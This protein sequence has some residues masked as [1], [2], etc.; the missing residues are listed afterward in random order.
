MRGHVTYPLNP[1]NF[2]RHLKKIGEICLPMILAVRINILAQ[3]GDFPKPISGRLTDFFQDVCRIATAL[4][5]SYIG[6]DTVSTEIIAA[7][8]NGN[9]GR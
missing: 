9:P 3:Q 1:F 7:E 5:A 6:N 4:P 2:V 8:H